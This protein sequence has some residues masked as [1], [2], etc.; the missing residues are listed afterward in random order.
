MKR[1]F[2][3]TVNVLQLFC[4]GILANSLLAQGPTFNHISTFNVSSQTPD[5]DEVCM[6][7]YDYKIFIQDD[8]TDEVDIYDANAPYSYIESFG[9]GIISDCEDGIQ[10]Y[11]GFIFVTDNGQRPIDDSIRVFTNTSPYN[12]VASFSHTTI[13]DI[14]GFKI[15]C[16]K[17][18]VADGGDDD[19]V[20][21]DVIAPYNFIT[22][23]GSGQLNSPDGVTSDGSRIFIGDDDHIDFFDCNTYDFLG[24]MTKG[25]GV[26]YSEGL[27][28][29]KNCKSILSIE[30][31]DNVV[32]VFNLDSPPIY[33]T[34]FE[35]GFF[36]DIECIAVAGNKIYL[37]NDDDD[38]ISIFECIPQPIPTIGEWGLTALSLLML[39][40]GSVAMRDFKTNSVKA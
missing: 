28:Y 34:S 29:D 39:I 26:D 32:D 33:Q 9:S 18:F 30:N 38:E 16:G 8:D 13:N 21:F 10:E 36:T 35:D 37:Y 20:V 15:S 27:V 6:M 2:R 4:L 3:N 7:V 24:S 40:F 5:G 14:E 23:F 31:N 17:I 22:S 11:D 1:M 19:I 12:L 25:A